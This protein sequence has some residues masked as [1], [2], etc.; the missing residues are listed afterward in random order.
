MKK[1]ISLV[2][3]FAM[4][5]VMS[6]SAFAMEKPTD[7]TA[8]DFATQLGEYYAELL[9]AEDADVAAIASEVVADYQNGLLTAENLPA[10]MEALVTNVADP[11]VL[12]D[13]IQQIQEGLENIGASLPEIDVP[14][15]PDI[16]D[17][18]DVPDVPDL[19]DLPDVTLP[20]NGENGEGGN[21]FLDTILG[22]LG[23]IGDLIFG[24]DPEDPEDPADPAD[25]ADPVDPDPVPDT[26]D[27]TVISVAAVALV[28]GAVLVLTRKKSEDAE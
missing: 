8:E 28:A 1:A 10:F 16:P 7:P 23:T 24:S 22:I 6:F 5:F 13:A 15:I 18:P 12:A 19:P 25:P 17:I 3:A 26:G 27:T 9:N 20:D 11:T 4:I 2:V 21:G 14:D